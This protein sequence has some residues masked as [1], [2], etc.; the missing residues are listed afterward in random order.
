MVKKPDYYNLK[1][2][3]LKLYYPKSHYN[4]AHRGAVFPL[5]KAFIKG[6]GFTDAQRKDMYG[7]TATDF[8][9]VD[10]LEEAELGILTMNW[11]YYTRTKQMD[12][13]IAFVKDCDEM[14]I[15]VM[16]WN[17]GDHGVKVPKLPNLLILRESGYCSK[18]SKNEFTLPS[19]INDPLRKFYKTD[20]PFVIPY[21]PIPMVGF[22]GQADYSIKSALQ[23]LAN[24]AAN[25]LKF[26][27]GISPEEPEALMST[28]YLRASVLR[29]LQ[30]A[31]NVNTN[32]ILRKKYR[33]GITKNKD[34]HKSTM[35]FY[36]NLKDSPYV[37]CIRGA[38]NFSVRF[39]EA[40]A[41]GRI[42]ILIDTDSSLPLDQ[43]INW[44]DHVV[45]VPYKDRN[46]VDALLVD[47]H[48]RHEKGG[49]EDLQLRN[50][51]L[52]EE[53]LGY[54]GYFK[55]MISLQSQP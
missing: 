21:E 17:A 43:D 14:G 55:K 33:A 36:D 26:Y 24:I 32:F 39:Y 54:G 45:W 48:N 7:V 38:G 18:F 8:Q 51:R 37:V 47:F 50:R 20:A 4:K 25:N 28:V 27:L 6:K 1:R 35:E 49:F 9:F 22:C 23:Q 10:S 29:K 44:K 40:L 12:Q 31:A 13:A 2:F 53:Y 46:R 34:Q 16:S 30:Q 41:M 19:F 15:K 11:N 52:W 42:P 3:I 5:L